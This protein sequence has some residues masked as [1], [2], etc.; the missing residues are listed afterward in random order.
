MT[1]T[2]NISAAALGERGFVSHERAIANYA[3]VTVEAAREGFREGLRLGA[4]TREP[5]SIIIRDGLYWFVRPSDAML[6]CY[7]PVPKIDWS[8]CTLTVSIGDAS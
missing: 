1:E 4:T 3:G 5:F 7:D 2:I 6:C 8:K